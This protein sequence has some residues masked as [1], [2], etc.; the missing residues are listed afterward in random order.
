MI[1]NSNSFGLADDPRTLPWVLQALM[2]SF[3]NGQLHA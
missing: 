3:W 1:S 2:A